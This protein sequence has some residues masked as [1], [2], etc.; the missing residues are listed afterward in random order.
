[1]DGRMPGRSCD[2]G[3]S[4]GREPNVLTNPRVLCP[5]QQTSQ[6]DKRLLLLGYLWLLE[7]PD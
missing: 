6:T 2:L 7:V 5:W 1:M 4:G 3:T